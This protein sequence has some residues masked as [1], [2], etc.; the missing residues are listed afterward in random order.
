MNYRSV[1]VYGYGTI[2]DE[3][4]SFFDKHPEYGYKFKG[5]FDSQDTP[6][7][8][9]GT[10]ADIEPYVEENE[11]DEI[12]CCL[13]YVEYSNIKKLVDYGDEALIKVKLMTDF[14][15]FSSKNVELE[16]YDHIPILSVNSTPLDDWKNRFVKRSFDIA[17]SSIIILGI[18]SWLYPIVA[19]LIK[20]DS[21]GPILFRQKRTGQDNKNFYCY[22]FRTMTLNLSSE[23][24]QATKNDQRIT[25][26][27]QFLRKTSIDEL[28]QFWNVLKGDMSVIGPRP[29]MLKHTE[30]YS[31]KIEKFMARHF[32]KPGITGLAQAKGFR[33]PTTQLYQMSNRVKLDRFYVEN[34]SLMLDIK[35][36]ALTAVSIMKGDE[37]AF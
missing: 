32:V 24:V 16:R 6:S 13:P 3:L 5:F 19:V 7:D 14:R 33:G 35:I 18:L 8:Y 9:L 2:A 29:H 36:L 20:L 26:L 1:I 22:K 37:N 31:H 27:G 30:E 12:Y 28:P 10:Y 17:I 15:G 34:W 25:G 21:R 11:V 4:I 23:S